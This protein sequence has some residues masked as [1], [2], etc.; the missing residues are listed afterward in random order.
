MNHVI[1]IRSAYPGTLD[2][3][4]LRRR[5]KYTHGV[6]VRSLLSQTSQD[7]KVIVAVRRDDQL[8][9]EREQVFRQLPIKCTLTTN[10][11]QELK[12]MEFPILQTRLDDD[13]A[14]AKTFV[15]RVQGRVD[16]AREKDLWYSIPKGV[17]VVNRRYAGM[18]NKGN[19]FISL[20][21]HSR[22]NTVFDVVHGRVGRREWGLSCRVVDQEIGWL[23]T[24]HPDA[25]SNGGKTRCIAG[26]NRIQKAFDID[27]SVF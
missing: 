1:I 12:E 10:W 15:E 21:T 2:K 14:L 6:C 19:Q 27:W 13:D 5:M 16:T 3:S 20:W 25:K 8:L 23:W 4:Y 9:G 22:E 24:R 18:Q 11:K 26:L 17:R 7:F